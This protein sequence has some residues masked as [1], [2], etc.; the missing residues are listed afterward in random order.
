MRY[1]CDIEL[2]VRPSVTS[3][4]TLV[5]IENTVSMISSFEFLVDWGG[6]T[7]V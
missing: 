4:V 5:M 2:L 1:L 6:G 3:S 7:T